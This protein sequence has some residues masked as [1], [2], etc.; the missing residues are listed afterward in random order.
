[1]KN[2]KWAI[3]LALL[4]AIIISYPQ[5]YFRYDHQDAYRG[6]DASLLTGDE[7]YYWSRIQEVRDGHLSLAS[8][9]FREGK[10]GPYSQPP[11]AEILAAF[12]GKLFFLD[13]NNTVFLTKFLLGFLLFLAI[14]SFVY[15][16]LKEKLMAV[17]SSS[18][19][20]FGITLLSRHGPEAE[21]LWFSRM[22]HPLVS[23]LFFFAFLSL[24]WLFLDGST[25]LT[26]RKQWISGAISALILGLSFYVYFYTWT[27]LYA[28]LGILILISLFQKDWQKIK[29][30]ILVLLLS[31]L[32][33]APYFI[34]LY[35]TIAYPGY[36][37]FQQR[38]G[39]VQG[40]T[41]ALG[42]LTPIALVIFLF[43]FPRGHRDRYFFSLAL[44]ITPLIVINQQLITGKILHPSH[45]HGSYNRFLAIIFLMII[46]LNMS[47]R[48]K[49]ILTILIIGAGFYTGFAIQS[50]SYAKY[51]DSFIRGQRYGPILEW[52]NKNAQKE[53]VVLAD[54]DLSRYIPIYTS[55]NVA[56]DGGYAIWYLSVPEERLLDNE[57][58]IYKLQGLRPQDAERV[59][60]RDR[61]L[62][63]FRIHGFYYQE[64]MGSPEA[65]PDE[66]L[67]EFGLKYQAFYEQPLEEYLIK[68]QV[69]YIVWDKETH[70]QW[71]LNQYK[72]LEKIVEIEDFAIYEYNL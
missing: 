24:F 35:Q 63:S 4:A 38:V 65:I 3:I 39:L 66:A 14:Y 37:E 69:K 27:F 45:W 21:F 72:F 31:L 50:A 43:L 25:K 17:A 41:P 30:I 18:M 26:T 5:I 54:Y 9:L 53:E 6:I 22:L 55:L 60:V 7:Y 49:K 64:K 12:L 20:F 23:S 56:Y 71:A 16:L 52:I 1:M 33:A 70:P 62:L 32:F 2:H 61:G 57:F 36:L 59:F 68:Y 29:K 46:F 58:L 28:F 42:Y 15:L 67:L 40:R 8:P 47:K 10:D 34:N 13:L 19:I 11:L 44:I 48:F 51:E